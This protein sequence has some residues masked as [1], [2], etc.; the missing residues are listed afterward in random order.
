M[1]HLFLQIALVP[2]SCQGVRLPSSNL[3]GGFQKP[4]GLQK[5]YLALKMYNDPI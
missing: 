2:W 4:L 3:A 5:F 1:S